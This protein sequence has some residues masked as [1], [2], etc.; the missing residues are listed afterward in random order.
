MR[1][2]DITFGPFQEA[3]DFFRSKINVPTA[4]WADV[5]REAHNVAFM[6]A[7]AQRADVIQDFRDAIDK[8]ISRGTT[9]EEF[10]KDFDSIVARH[11]WSFNGGRGWRTRIIYE[12]NL[13]GAYA[14]G[15]FRQLTDPDLLSLRPWWQ[16]HHSDAVANPRPL[17]VSWDG[18]ILR[19]DNPWWRTHYPPNG[20]GCQCSV[21]ALGKR[22]L[23]RLGKK[24]PDKAPTDG[25]REFVDKV[26][27]EVHQV[28]KGIDPGFDFTPGAPVDKRVQALMLKK[29]QTMDTALADRLRKSVNTV[30]ARPKNL[31]DYLAAGD[32]WVDELSNGLDPAA[33]DFGLKLRRR[34]RDRLPL[35]RPIG[36]AAKI[37]NG[38]KGARLV[39]EASQ[40][41]PDTW[42]ALADEFGAL[43]VKMKQS[44]GGATTLLFGDAPEGARVTVKGF[45]AVTFHAGEGYL[46]V[47]DPR[48]AM[49]E[50]MHR[51]QKAIPALDELFQQLHRRR[52]A[53]ENLQLLSRLMHDDRYRQELARPDKYLNPYFGREYGGDRPA[54]EVLTMAFQYVLADKPE[55]L[56]LMHR[57]DVELLQLVLGVLFHFEP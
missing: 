56:A 6:V 7:G 10:R 25:S 47:R 33:P 48:N 49:H 27:G 41:L 3:L 9:L 17:H 29:A 21:T 12:T 19:H 16:Y 50:F 51:I 57:S 53:D 23:E 38:G 20:W 2:I 15:R 54:R 40:L 18:L 31:D 1:S 32:R 52:T 46:V 37:A 44:R 5:W 39:R 55:N 42:T 8:A 26:T 34:I 4:R 30:E 43:H 14:A 45:G 28:P 13:R 22:D 11:G 24:G 36:T 35:V